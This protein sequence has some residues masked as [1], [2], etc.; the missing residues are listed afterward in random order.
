MATSSG[1]TEFERYD[2]AVAHILEIVY[3]TVRY[4][5][6]GRR[7][8]LK[9][10]GSESLDQLVHSCVYDKLP[11]ALRVAD[12]MPH[13]GDLVIRLRRGRR[14]FCLCGKH[15]ASVH[16]AVVE[17]GR[18]VTLSSSSWVWLARRR[19]VVKELDRAKA[20]LKRESVEVRER[21]ALAGDKKAPV[22]RQKVECAKRVKKKEK[23][24]H[25]VWQIIQ[26]ENAVV[27]CSKDQ[28]IANKHNKVCERKIMDGT[29]KRIDAGKVAQIRYEF[30][31][32]DRHRKQNHRKRP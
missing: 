30:T 29:C 19:G 25:H 6:G 3:L 31:H 18:F 32:P 9:E 13:V 14:V 21:L 22:K 1:K 17:L 10:D 20:V 5:M 11:N 2:K 4:L 24:W 12:S 8:R 16:A 7:G 26:E 28:K 27:A 15:G 23:K